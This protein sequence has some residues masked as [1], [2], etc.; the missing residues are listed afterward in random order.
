MIKKIKLSIFS[1]ITLTLMIVF[2]PMLFNHPKPT[3]VYAAQ[4]VKIHDEALKT[5][6][7]ELL[8]KTTFYSND[9][10]KSDIYNPVDTET[11][12]KTCLDLSNSGIT[13]ITDLVQFEFPTTLANINLAGNNINTKQ[14][15]KI[16]NTLSAEINQELYY[17]NDPLDDSKDI[18]VKSVTHMLD[19]FDTINVAFN[20]IDLTDQLIHDSNEHYISR[21]YIFGVQKFD[22]LQ[23]GMILTKDEINAVIYIDNGENRDRNHITFNV[24]LENQCNTEDSSNLHTNYP[25]KTIIELADLNYLGRYT[26]TF[27]SNELVNVDSPFVGWSH[28]INFILIKAYFKPTENTDIYTVERLSNFSVSKENIVVRG[29]D[30]LNILDKNNNIGGKTQ[31]IGTFQAP[32]LLEVENFPVKTILL[33]YKVV[34]TTPPVLSLKGSETMLWKL[35]TTWKDPG[36]I[37]SDN[38]A[39]EDIPVTPTGIVDYITE[40]T[41]TLT[42]VTNDISGNTSQPITRTVI[43][44]NGVIT[45]IELTLTTTQITENDFVTIYAKPDI[46]FDKSL[47][48]DIEYDWFINDEFVETTKAGTS[49]SATFRYLPTNTNDFSVKAKIRCKI[50]ADGSL[51]ELSSESLNLKATSVF[52]SEKIMTIVLIAGGSIMLCLIIAIIVKLKKSKKITKKSKGGSKGKGNSKDSPQEKNIDIQIINSSNPN[53]E[54]YKPN[55]EKVVEKPEND[56]NANKLV[57][58]NTQTDSTNNNTQSSNNST[59]PFDW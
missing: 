23:N 55:K 1:I 5:R 57:D 35:N 13:D 27:T 46:T 16:R 59:N 9:F 8:G 53:S 19:Q 38:G 58:N 43:V 28:S 4:S 47:Y 20:Q 50:V 2:F 40:G 52:G 41:Y 48:Y 33:D 22:P 12:A 31:N 14:F 29:I 51:F 3:Q 7:S 49:G 15:E 54:P 44:S 24:K 30:Y 25:N 10:I 42:Y 45:K 26:V 11:K 21:H 32:V 18:V 36:I 17:Y 56:P 6:L 39:V 34:D 37:Y